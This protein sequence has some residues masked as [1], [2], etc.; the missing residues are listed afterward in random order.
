MIRPTPALWN[1]DR[2]V[3][4]DL[5]GNQLIGIGLIAIFAGNFHRFH[6]NGRITEDLLDKHPELVNDLRL[7]AFFC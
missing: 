5:T 4:A 7:T 1:T 3:G 2:C 6:R